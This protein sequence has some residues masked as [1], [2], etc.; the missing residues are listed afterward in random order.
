MFDWKFEI[1]AWRFLP[2]EL[3]LAGRYFYAR[4]R[5]P[6]A[7]VT[8]AAAVLSLA[9]GVAAL[10]AALALGRGWQ[11]EISDKI[12]RGTAHIV[13]MRRDGSP[14]PDWRVYAAR[15][16]QISGVTHVSGTTYEGALVSGPEGGQYA[17]LRGV[18]PDD[19]RAADALQKVLAEGAFM[20]QNGMAQAV[21]GADLAARMGLR[22]G[23]RAE[24][25]TGAAALS[26]GPL[27]PQQLEITG[28][29]RTGW[30]DYDTTW[31][32]LPLSVA[33]RLAGA[34]KDTATALN[35]EVADTYA[36][37]TVTQRVR[38]TLG[39]D[40][41]VTDWQEANRPLF[42]A[43][44]LE[45]RAGWLAIGLLIALAALNILATFV[46]VVAERRS[47]IVV[48]VAL[49]ARAR[50]IMLI[51]MAEGALIG[52]LGTACGLGLGLLLCALGNYYRWVSLPGAVYALNYVPF[53]VHS[54][55]VLQVMGLAFMLSLL[56]TLYPAWAAARV[57][58]A[59]ALKK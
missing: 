14:W 28:L 34:G 53:R 4:R 50:S 54:E 18:A 48:V 39:D 16:R 11:E 46:L 59:E 21:I 42:A 58:P 17:V 35:I 2:F 36:V 31:V 22:V 13:I 51:F 9:L 55:D 40:F 3:F 32:Y 38:A 57:L 33:A 44:A 25:V 15:L 41:R 20:P 12:L 10:L 27:Q 37:G 56:A 6:L 24:I 5:R 19:T 45:R 30:H 47:E 52:F 1:A 7:R 29:F 26:S 8:G 49:G 43:L 23:D